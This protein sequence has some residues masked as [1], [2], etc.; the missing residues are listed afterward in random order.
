M[1]ARKIS[2]DTAQQAETPLVNLFAFIRD[3]YQS[4]GSSLR[5]DQK[6][7][8]RTEEGRDWWQLASLH[9][10]IHAQG[11]PLGAHWQ[12]EDPEKPLLRLQPIDLAEAPDLPEAL[13]G[14]V[15]I[16]PK[17]AEPIAPLPH[18]VATFEE[19]PERVQAWET[20]QQSFKE[21]PAEA[22][23]P[24]VLAGWVMLESSESDA[25]PAVLPQKEVE[26]EADELRVELFKAYRRQYLDWKEQHAATEIL[27]EAYEQLHEAC[28]R[29]QGDDGLSLYLSMGQVAWSDG[30]DIYRQFLFHFPVKLTLQGP[31]IIL[32][33]DTLDR[34][35]ELDDKV[36]DWLEHLDP[37]NFAT[38]QSARHARMLRSIEAWNQ[39]GHQF[40]L[41]QDY[42][43][44]HLYQPARELLAVFAGVKDE[45]FDGNKL[46]WE[47]PENIKAKRLHLRFSPVLQIRDEAAQQH[48]VQDAARVIACINRLG[49]EGRNEE[50]PDFFKKMFSLRRAGNPLRIA[51]RRANLR[52]ATPEI[53]QEIEAPRLR[54]PLPYNAEQ[55]A[56]ADRLWEQ[57]AVTVKGPP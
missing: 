55:Q 13:E 51:F 37:S 50:I 30:E 47:W 20:W 44:L 19:N 56:I 33:P 54:F 24:E 14:W 11:G 7:D 26:F 1:L 52:A 53:S 22:I 48:I 10:I 23:L 28:F 46:N 31:E 45:F 40:D 18:Q 39:N 4:E 27:H 34:G 35:I 6:G 17:A 8:K 32:V 25:Q 57:D 49:A 3:L 42:I 43:K 41:T 29:V 15:E 38:Q 9:A 5:F 21:N 2:Q 36:L 12:W 16:R